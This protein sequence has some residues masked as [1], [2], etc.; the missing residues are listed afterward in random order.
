MEV[1]CVA[2]FLPPVLCTM[3]VMLLLFNWVPFFMS[4]VDWVVELL[5]ASLLP[6]WF[7][8]KAV[9]DAVYWKRRYLILRQSYVQFPVRCRWSLLLPILFEIQCE[10]NDAVGVC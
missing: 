1:W 8:L 6:A 2:A 5:L 4:L 9:I 10:R 7:L 3:G